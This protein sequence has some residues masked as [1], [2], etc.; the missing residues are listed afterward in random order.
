ME[1]TSRDVAKTNTNVIEEINCNSEY[2]AMASLYN[3]RYSEDIYRDDSDLNWRIVRNT[4]KLSIDDKWGRYLVAQT[5]E[6]I[7]K[8]DLNSCE[9]EISLSCW[10]KN[11]QSYY[12]VK[13]WRS[14]FNYDTNCKAV[15]EVIQTCIK[16]GKFEIE[17]IEQSKLKISLGTGIIDSKTNS[18]GE[19][20]YYTCI[21]V[22]LDKTE[23][24]EFKIPFLSYSDEVKYIKKEINSPDENVY[25]QLAVISKNNKYLKHQRKLLIDANLALESKMHDLTRNLIKFNDAYQ[26]LEK[27][28]N[29]LKNEYDEF[30]RAHE[31]LKN[32]NDKFRKTHEQLESKHD[33]LKK[34]IKKLEETIENSP[35]IL[36]DYRY[37][38]SINT[39][40]IYEA[41]SSHIE[42]DMDRRYRSDA[43]PD[44]WRIEQFNNLKSLRIMNWLHSD[45]FKI[46]YNCKFMNSNTLEKLVIENA[47]LLQSIDGLKNMPNLEVL[48]VINAPQLTEIVSVLSKYEHWINLITLKGCNNVDKESLQKYCETNNI[49]LNIS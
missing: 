12:N 34:Q 10:E 30:K 42:V 39:K 49:Q 16:G 18:T 5:E 19:T 7:I 45:Y 41:N 38:D 14:M 28:N 33:E 20:V 27:E 46:N 17:Q 22:I 36:C 37:G 35:I 24:C 31:Q 25:N 1:I 3:V 23:F 9:N 47:P 43:M 11:K 15:Y 44:L 21:E 32:E 40:H 4:L 26:K 8:V 2:F 6:Y 13:L 48:E 29:E